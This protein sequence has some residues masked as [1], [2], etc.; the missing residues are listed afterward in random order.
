MHT[1]SPPVCPCLSALLV[2]GR[3]DSAVIL[4]RYRAATGATCPPV[5]TRHFGEILVDVERSPFQRSPRGGTSGA[6]KIVDDGLLEAPSTRESREEAGSTV[7][8]LFRAQSRR[9]AGFL[10]GKLRNES[11]AEDASQEVFLNLW[12]REKAGQL[13]EDASSYLFTAARN[14][15]VDCER[16][17]QTHR[18][19]QTVELEENGID[20][21]ADPG[22]APA[23]EA[24]H[25]RQG[26]VALVSSLE[27]LPAKTQK[28]FVLYHFESL[29]YADIA[30]RLGISER[31]VERHMARAF[32]HCRKVLEEY[33]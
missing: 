30:A 18:A 13:R 20:E 1:L 26:L 7:V 29:D 16:K 9:V 8:R 15:A 32:A 24:Q 3:R 31:S 11:D 19:D 10:L 33:L 22:I 28:I 17:R 2:R 25:W 27:A 21:I 14:V 5:F 6:V 23:D 12:R 4:G